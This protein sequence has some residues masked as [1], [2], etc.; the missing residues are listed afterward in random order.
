MLLHPLVAPCCHVAGRCNVAARLAQVKVTIDERTP[1]PV[2]RAEWPA[3]RR[4]TTVVRARAR[5]GHAALGARR[6]LAAA[7]EG[8][9]NLRAAG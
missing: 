9:D 7:E 4:P 3:A 5:G 1:A 8:Q 6:V 2:R